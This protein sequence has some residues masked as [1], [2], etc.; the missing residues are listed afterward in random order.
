MQPRHWN[1][2][3]EDE[4]ELDFSK[5]RSSASSALAS[6]DP[7]L[8][9]ASQSRMDVAEETSYDDD[10]EALEHELKGGTSKAASEPTGLLAGLLESL[11][12]NIVGK[13]ALSADD[14][15]KTVGTMQKRLQVD[16]KCFCHLQS[17]DFRIGMSQEESLICSQH[18][19]LVLA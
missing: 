10:D 4:E 6:L 12:T 7:T 5:P 18:V 14:I 17:L 11:R 15:A 3:S 9:S 1:G 8:A 16:P 19:D 13:E 2:A